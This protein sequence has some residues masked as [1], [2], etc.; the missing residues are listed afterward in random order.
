MY[1][2]I[3]VSGELHL[4]DAST[5]NMYAIYFAAKLTNILYTIRHTITY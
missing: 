5:I 3:P 2:K 1:A 4:V